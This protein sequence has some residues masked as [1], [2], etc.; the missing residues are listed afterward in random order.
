MTSAL[1]A[2]GITS[3]EQPEQLQFIQIGGREFAYVYSFKF[4]IVEIKEWIL[5][6]LL[7]A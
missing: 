4:H 6:R 5:F 7:V 1:A 2:T 3:A